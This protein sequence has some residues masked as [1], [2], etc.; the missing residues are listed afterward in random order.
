MRSFLPLLS[1]YGGYQYPSI[2]LFSLFLGWAG[3]DRFCLQWTCLG[4]V[5]MLTIGGLGVWW[6]TDLILL[7]LGQLAPADG[8]LWDPSW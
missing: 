7:T 3:V 6:L 2:V 5:K 4:T 8:S 1:R